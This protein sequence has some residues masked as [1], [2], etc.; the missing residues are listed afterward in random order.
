[1]AAPP[2]QGFINHLVHGLDVERPV[3]ESVITR[4][5]E[6]LI[7]Q[8][9][10]KHP[11]QTYYQAAMAALASG[12][13][14]GGTG[15]PEV[16]RDLLARLVDELDARRPWAE[17]PYRTLDRNHWG[18]L[19]AAP[20]IGHIPLSRLA[21]SERLYGIFEPVVEG[22]RDDVLVVRLRTGGL[23]GLVAPASFTDRGVTVRGY[24]DRSSR[25]P[26]SASSPAS[27]SRPTDPKDRDDRADGKSHGVV[28]TTRTS[29]GVRCVIAAGT[30][31]RIR[32]LSVLSPRLPTT[33][34]SAS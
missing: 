34:R 25:S 18:A 3:D 26:R 31:P 22:G 28:C 21:V 7:E 19:E 1:M 33:T 23:I 32:P 12:Q 16:V 8:R 4:L 6:A 2:G 27:T 5:A 9:S 29:H 13:P 30:E 20:V 14:T 10:F 15:E 24:R 11:V 17:P